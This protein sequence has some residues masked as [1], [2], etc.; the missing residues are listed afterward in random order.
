MTVAD[1]LGGELSLV[2]GLDGALDAD[3][4]THWPTPV[5][6]G[7]PFL[8]A[9]VELLMHDAIVKRS[10]LGV[11]GRGLDAGREGCVSLG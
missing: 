2:V 6:A 7:C 8:V 1:M 5:T 10:S 4:P 3:S 9:V 11:L